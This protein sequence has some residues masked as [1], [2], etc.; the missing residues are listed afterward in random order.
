MKSDEKTKDEKPAITESERHA[1]A[2]KYVVD[3]KADSARYYD[4]KFKSFNYYD[5]LYIQ[6]SAKTNTPYGRANLKLPLAFQQIEPYVSQMTEAMVGEA[7]YIKYN[8]RNLQDEPLAVQIT[9]YTQYQLD[10]GGFLIPFTQ[11]LRNLGKYGSAVLKVVWETETLEIEDE[12]IQYRWT[13]DPESQEPKMVHDIISTPRDLVKKDGP[14][15]Y[16][17]SIFDFFIPKSATSCDVQKMEWVIDRTWRTLD[18]LYDNPNYTMARAKIGKLLNKE[19][20]T[21]DAADTA[22]NLQGDQA[23]SHKLTELQQKNP[24][25]AQKFAGKAEVLEF[26]GDYKLTEKGRPEAALITVALINGEKIVLRFE[27]NPFKFKFKPFIMAN[28]YPIEGEAYGY[29]ELHHITG[30][31]DESTALRNARLDVA[32]I[33]LNRIWL[34]ERQANVNTRELITAPNKIVMTDDLQGIK[35][36]DMAGVTPS[37]VQELAR[38]DWDI[39][40]TTDIVNPRQDVSSVGAGFGSTATGVNF[41][42]SK[43]NL[44][45][46]TKARLLEEMVFKPLANMLDYYNKDVLAETKVPGEDPASYYFR[47]TNEENPYGQISAE[48]FLTDVDFAPTSNP[49]KL[50][51]GQQREN[52]SYLLQVV[53]QIEKAKPGT[54]NLPELLKEVY[55]LSGFTHPDKY[56]NPGT[57][58]VMQMP[59]GQMV[60]Q[61]GRPVQVMQMGPDGQPVPAPPTG[62]A[63]NGIS[64]T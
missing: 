33:S 3:C 30:L 27:K 23:D 40:N 14:G 61:N 28:D 17:K 50:N 59:D 19:D 42:S 6:G 46:L 25:G 55:R 45:M 11:Y 43:G 39:Q 5:R 22:S 31:I 35:A 37:S 51:Q 16:N 2:A 12:Q 44:R 56:V 32:N 48:V 60:D 41:L 36:L 21:D 20:D 49:Q 63:P 29:G 58:T 57:T 53:A 62:G 26:W 38:I 10:V 64:G 8:A 34:V 7:P 47:R 1:K 54:N 4:A 13:M 9:D 15:F 52:M 24:N 18:E